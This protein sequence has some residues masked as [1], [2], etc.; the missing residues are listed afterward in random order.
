VIACYFFVSTLSLQEALKYNEKIRDPVIKLKRG[1][2]FQYLALS[3][4]TY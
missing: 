3:Y 1:L 2:Y 4:I